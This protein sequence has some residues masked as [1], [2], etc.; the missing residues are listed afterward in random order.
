MDTVLRV[1]A[2]LDSDLEMELAALRDVMDTEELFT[3]L[4]DSVRAAIHAKWKALVDGE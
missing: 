2:Q 1:D 4:E 3:Y